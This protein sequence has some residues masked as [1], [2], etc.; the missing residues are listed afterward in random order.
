MAIPRADIEGPIAPDEF[1]VQTR[2]LCDS[3][4]KHRSEDTQSLFGDLHKM[5]TL[6]Y[7]GALSQANHSFW[8]AQGF[9]ILGTAL[10]LVGGAMWMR[11]HREPH[12]LAALVGLGLQVI[13]GLNFYL[14]RKATKQFELF[15]VCLERMGRY[16]MANSVCASIQD[17]GKRDEART[18]LAGVMANAPM[19]PAECLQD[20]N[21]EPSQS[22]AS[23]AHPD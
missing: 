2:A 13:S 8:G 15:H 7:R 16:L 12:G 9:A 4:S 21:R 18:A 14:Y 22:S 5:A 10:F 23:V 17:P 19:L 6:Y 11:Q 3:V 1:V 20:Q